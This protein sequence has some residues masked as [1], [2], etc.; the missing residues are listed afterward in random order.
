MHT[1]QA[2]EFQLL[3]QCFRENPES[4]WQRNK[5]LAYQWD[6]KTFRQA[7]DNY[8]FVPQADPNTASQSQRL[9]KI[10]ALK[11]LATATPALYDPIAVDTAALQALGWSNPQ[12]FMVPPQ[13]LAEKPPPEMLKAMADIENSKSN[14]AARMMDSQT[15]AREIDAKIAED[16][17]RLAME[18]EKSKD[19]MSDKMMDAH[20]D[21]QN[22]M[23]QERIQLIDLAQDI[24]QHPENIPLIEPLIRPALEEIYNVPPKPGGQ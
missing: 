19:G 18:A 2:K 14:A 21:H 8:E 10:A 3:V 17:A 20:N 16:Q 13:S 9:M 4:F 7:L 5:R 22:R 11:Q 12:Q 1:S 15:R 23:S 24:L 6:E